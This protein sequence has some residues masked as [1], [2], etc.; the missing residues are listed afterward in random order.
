MIIFNFRY[1]NFIHVHIYSD[2]QIYLYSHIIHNHTHIFI[3]IHI[4]IYSDTQI[5]FIFKYYS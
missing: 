2:T 5:L 4:H 1:S 3:Y